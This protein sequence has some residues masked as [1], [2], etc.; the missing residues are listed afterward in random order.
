MRPNL[1]KSE[2]ADSINYADLFRM[3]GKRWMMME[4]GKSQTARIA[5]VSVRENDTGRDCAEI[6]D[7]HGVLEAR[8]DSGAR[9]EGSR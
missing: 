9:F 8:Y 6:R 2:Y 4:C 7:N 5:S 1:I 3:G